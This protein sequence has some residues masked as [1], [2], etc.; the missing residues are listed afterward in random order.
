[1]L[2]RKNLSKLFTE[3]V[4]DTFIANKNCLDLIE[5]L[6]DKVD[7]LITDPPYNLGL[8]MHRRNTNLKKMRENHFSASNWD[9]LEHEDWIKYVDEFFEK[10]T[11][12]MNKKGSLIIFMSLIKVESVIKI[13]EKHGFYYKTTGA[14]HKTNPMPRNMNIH[15]VNSIEGWIYFIYKGTSGTFNNNGKMMHDYIETSITPMGEKK[16]G[17]HPTQKPIKLI[18]H[19]IKTLS[20]KGDVV[21]DPFMGSGTSAVVSYR[22]K[23]KFYGIELEKDYFE[24]TEKRLIDEDS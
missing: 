12:I 2:L 1:M 7:L 3:C 6:D 19:F 5:K 21:F 16:F 24:I 11:K 20:N 23:R 14:W 22:L 9:N 18:E 4:K 13:A 15:F 17:K 10:T 8:F